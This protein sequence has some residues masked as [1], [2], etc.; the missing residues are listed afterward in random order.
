MKTLLNILT[1]LILTA[2]IANGQTM[3]KTLQ[4]LID[5]KLI[6]QKQTNDFEEFLKKSETKSNAVYLTILFQSEY[7]KLTGHNYSQFGS[8]ISFGDEKPKI[9]ANSN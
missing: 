5:I 2:N 8:Y 7:K 4:K 1:L 6:E 3:D 9:L